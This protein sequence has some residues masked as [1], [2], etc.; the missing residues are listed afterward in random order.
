MTGSGITVKKLKK[1]LKQ[2]FL[3]LSQNTYS[4]VSFFER[5]PLKEVAEWVDAIEDNAKR[6]KKR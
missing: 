4:P 2:L 3:S 5:M 1:R 6:M